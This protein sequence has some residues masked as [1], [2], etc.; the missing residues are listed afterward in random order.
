MPQNPEDPA[1]SI[2]LTSAPTL[3]QTGETGDLITIAKYIDPMRAQ[4]AKGMLESM[5]IPVF[6]QGEHANQLLSLSFRA[7]L[8]VRAG[9]EAAARE[10]LGPADEDLVD[11]DEFKGEE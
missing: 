6:L 3:D 7:R 4:M 5:G 11:D 8:Q 9:D 1:D 10:A 2:A